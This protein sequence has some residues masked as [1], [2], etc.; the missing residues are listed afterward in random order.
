MRIFYIGQ[1]GMMIV[2]NSTLKNFLNWL[3]GLPKCKKGGRCNSDLE[4]QYTLSSKKFFQK[5][6]R[7]VCSKCG[8]EMT[9]YF[10]I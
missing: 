1:N 9:E 4:I 8:K 3:I 7:Y 5:S 6:N 10:K 2:M